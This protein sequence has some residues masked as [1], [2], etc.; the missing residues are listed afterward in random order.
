MPSAPLG[1]SARHTARAA[2]DLGALGRRLSVVRLPDVNTHTDFTFE[3]KITFRADGDNPVFVRVTDED[4]HQA[5]TSPIYV[6]R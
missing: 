3:R 5:W 4:G 6:Y 2:Q 1:S